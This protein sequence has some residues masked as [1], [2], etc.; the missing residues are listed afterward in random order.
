MKLKFSFAFI[1]AALCAGLLGSSEPS[2]RN[3]ELVNRFDQIIQTRFRDPMPQTLG[4]NRAVTANSFG[5]NYQPILTDL[6]DFM[7]QNPAESSLLA[8]LEQQH[9]QL[10]IYVFGSDVVRSE[11]AALNLRALK[12]PAAITAGTPRPPWYPANV[13]NSG[14]VAAPPLATLRDESSNRTVAKDA[15]PDWLEIYSTARGAMKSFPE[16]GKGFETAV[17]W[18]ATR[19]WCPGEPRSSYS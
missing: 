8:E 17:A 13:E 11:P 7:P 3:I 14:H 19:P 16:G 9:V 10:G 2:P 18:R 15:L 4:M 5:R 6:R 12:G 1:A